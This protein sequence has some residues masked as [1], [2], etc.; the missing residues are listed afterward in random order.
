VLDYLPEKVGA[1]SKNVVVFTAGWA[2]KMVPML[3]DMLKDLLL[4]P[5]EEPSPVRKEGLKHFSIERSDGEKSVIRWPEPVPRGL[6]G[7]SFDGPRA[8]GR[9]QWQALLSPQVRHCLATGMTPASLRAALPGGPFKAPVNS[10]TGPLHVGVLGAGMAGLY[11]TM[12]LQSLGISCEV[13]EAAA[14][15]GGRVRTHCFSDPPQKWDYIDLG[16]MRF[17]NITVMERVGANPEPKSWSLVA[18]LN[19]HRGENEQ[20]K[21]GDYFYS[22]KNTITMYNE[23]RVVK[24]DLNCM[25]DGGVN[26]A[27]DPFGFSKKRGGNVP[28]EYVMGPIAGLKLCVDGHMMQ[29][30]DWQGPSS[31]LEAVIK[32]YVNALVDDFDTGFLKLMRL[33]N[34][35][36]RQVLY[37]RYKSETVVTFIETAGSEVTGYFEKSASEVVI[38]NM[39]FGEEDAKWY[40]F[41]GGTSKLTEAMFDSVRSSGSGNP[42]KIEHQ[43]QKLA[44]AG[45]CIIASGVVGGLGG[46]PFVK[47]FSHVITTVTN[48]A[49]RLIDTTGCKLSVAKKTA[50]RCLTYDHSTK[51]ALK[52]KTRFW[53]EGPSPIKGGSSTTDMPIRQVVYPSYGSECDTGVIIASYTWS[54]DADNMGNLSVHDEPRALELCIKNLAKLHSKPYAELKEACVGYKFMDWAAEKN[55]LGAYAMF[56]PGQFR[57]QFLDL[58]CPSTED[59]LFFAGEHASV[60]HAWIVGSLNS[61]YRCV[62]ELLKREGLNHK[63]IELRKQWGECE[64][65]DAEIR[66]LDAD[67]VFKTIQ[68]AAADDEKAAKG[69]LC[70]WRQVP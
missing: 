20:I 1:G 26:W 13:L 58:I 68:K 69:L 46:E 6:G 70:G 30:E 31:L 16:A 61:A 42:V 41:E 35:T 64:E 17:P 45:Q 3:G 51:V 29:A 48:H 63:R 9:G 57:S 21:I 36:M 59:R 25:P 65:S 39:D 55:A 67:A 40:L 2:M 43:V 5:D 10:T 62:D 19:E 7:E 33:D 50:I 53:E 8:V 22:A 23:V 44:H 66:F 54:D 34:K 52:F 32:P 4:H 60:H 27:I 24:G 14:K 49:F 18:K 56:T 47:E 28:D 12:L 38:D 11:S 37:E 15:P